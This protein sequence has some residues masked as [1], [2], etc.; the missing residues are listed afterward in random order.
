MKS[1]EVRM[2]ITWIITWK[3]RRERVCLDFPPR[4]RT[5]VWVE[6]PFSHHVTMEPSGSLSP[7]LAFC[8]IYVAHTHTAKTEQGY[9]IALKACSI[10]GGTPFAFWP[11]TQAVTQS[12]WVW[13]LVVW[14]TMRILLACQRCVY[15][16]LPASGLALCPGCCSVWHPCC[17]LAC[18]SIPAALEMRF[19][20][21]FLP[22]LMRP[23]CGTQWHTKCSAR[24]R[25]PYSVHFGF[26]V[27]VI[28]LLC[29]LM[30]FPPSACCALLAI[31]C[32]IF[33]P[34]AASRL[35]LKPFGCNRNRITAAVKRCKWQQTKRNA[36]T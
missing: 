23:P 25:V 16:P 34:T 13:V 4:T 35:P 19:I 22:R 10:C 12:C 18:P 29:P 3:G 17:L 20:Y 33:F 5:W 36:P 8:I 15:A 28:C 7:S 9:T 31:F 26:H 24:K 6:V 27:I 14:R 30:P 2:T 21:N 11:R 1:Y 32:A